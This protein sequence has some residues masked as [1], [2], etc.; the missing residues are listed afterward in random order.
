MKKRII[1]FL[2]AGLIFISQGEMSALACEEQAQEDAIMAVSESEVAV[3]G[4]TVTPASVTA[5]GGTVQLTVEGTGLTADN[6]GV[7]V[8][9]Y[10]AGL[11]VSMDDRLKAQVSDIN[12]KGA[13]ITVPANTMK[14][15]IE[16]RVMA[17]V[18]NGSSVQQQ[19]QAVISQEPKGET[20][21][22]EVKSVEMT[23]NFTVKAILGQS[24]TAALADAEALK[25]KIFIADFGNESSNKM[26]LGEKDVVTVSGNTVTIKLEYT[27]TATSL[28]ALYIQ[29]GALKTEEGITVKSI[30]HFITSKPSITEIAFDKDIYDSKG[31]QVTAR[32]KGVRLDELGT[33][34]AKVFLAGESKAT[35]IPVNITEGTEPVITFEVPENATDRTISYFLKVTVAGQPV[36]EATAENPAKRAIV[37]VLAEGVPETARTLGAMTITGNNR[38]EDESGTES[39]E[40]TVNVSKQLGELKVVLRLA[41]TNMDARMTKVRAIDENGVLWPVYD[42]PE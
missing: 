15:N 24:V 40:I 3:T 5:A 6:W 7:E 12:D 27:F 11:D 25:E 36:Y 9:S 39:K 29:E 23:D 30:K 35:D 38:V 14:N 22:V 19:A 4:I 31:G 1:S 41:G 13:V 21:D 17:G 16:Y 28:S 10:I 2:L 8:H 32:L 26:S 42:I 18:K 34:D 33:I 20:V 37:S